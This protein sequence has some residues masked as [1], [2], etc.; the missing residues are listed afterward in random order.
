MIALS[1]VVQSF[2]RSALGNVDENM[3]YE[4]RYSPAQKKTTDIFTML[5]VEFICGPTWA[6]TRDS[7]IMSQVL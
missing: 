3:N 6:R 2:A 5:V 4:L 1:A 7:L